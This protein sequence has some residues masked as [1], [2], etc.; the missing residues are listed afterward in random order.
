MWSTLYSRT[1]CVQNGLSCELSFELFRSRLRIVKIGIGIL[2]IVLLARMAYLQLWQHQRYH[3]L[4]AQN[5]IRLIPIPAPRGLIFDRD[6]TLL[7]DNRT[8]FQLS[9]SHDLTQPVE[10]TLLRLQNLGLI[11][12]EDIALFKKRR[13]HRQLLSSTLLKGTLTEEAVATFALHRYEFADVNLETTLI[14]HYPHGPIFSHVLGYLGEISDKDLQSIDPTLYRG[15][16]T[17][18]KVGIEKIYESSLHGISGYKQA[19]TNAEGRIVR[20]LDNTP[21]TPGQSLTLTLDAKLQTIAYHALG[22]QKGALIAIEPKTGSVL[23]LVST[24]GFDP[25]LFTTGIDASNYQQLQSDPKLPLFNRAVQGQYPP[26]STIKP[27]VAILGLK[28]KVITPQ[29]TIVDPGWFQLTPQ[30]RRYRD[31]KEYGHGEVDL[32]HAIIQSCDTYYYRLANRLGGKTLSEGLLTFGYGK[33]TEIDLTHE[34]AG[35]VPTPAWK[36]AL[37]Q[38]PWY[39]GETLNLGIGQGYLLATPLQMAQTAS[40][41]A[42]RGVQYVPHLL[43]HVGNHPAPPPKI[44]RSVEAP[45]HLWNTVI[46][47]MQGVVKNPR[48]TAH[49]LNHRKPYSMAAKTGTAQVFSLKSNEK[50]EA[51]RLSTHLRD[52]SLFIAFAPVEQPG[53]AIAVVLENSK[54]AAKA[55]QQVLDAYCEEHCH[56]DP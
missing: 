18:G 51:H 33:P 21:P 53:I 13:Q 37:F 35:F 5:Q 14:R 8:S 31:W 47:A 4:A 1:F 49:Y 34:R 52:H 38:Q 23:A 6:G 28:E 55:A 41:I 26:A 42:N 54:G 11:N 17:I 48:G 50:Y 7:A 15:T 30:G 2:F 24:P 19:E 9:L 32:N 39:P 12:A 25:N 44:A 16:S 3:A 36:E 27:L 43:D 10:Q 29:T 45:T 56:V 22:E 20:T 40:L 46:E